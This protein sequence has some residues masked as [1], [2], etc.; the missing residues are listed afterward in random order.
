MSAI[1]MKNLSKRCSRGMKQR[2]GI[3]M[4]LLGDPTLLALGKLQ[5]VGTHYEIIRHGKMIVE[6]TAE[7][8]DASCRTY[9]ALQSEKMK[10]TK[11][12]LCCKFSRV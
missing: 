1:E 10:R 12:L 4:A 2:I 9:V 11:M 8:L 5:K 3:A 6:M 7:E